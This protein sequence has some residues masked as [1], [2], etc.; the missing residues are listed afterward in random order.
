MTAERI[1][2]STIRL[3]S[4]TISRITTPSAEAFSWNVACSALDGLPGSGLNIAHEAIDRHVARG[5]GA[6]T[7]V[8]G[9]PGSVPSFR[10]HNAYSKLPGMTCRSK[11]TGRSFKPLCIGLNCAM[12][13]SPSFYLAVKLWQ[14]AKCFLVGFGFFLQ[15]QRRASRRC[16]AL[17]RSVQ[18][19]KGAGLSAG[20][21]FVISIN[22]FFYC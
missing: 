18:R 11:S 12:S 1:A 8:G 21:D 9:K 17:S 13:H 22:F 4:H 7:A 3:A 10:W 5:A 19:L 6:K 15:P 16:A 14:I 20:L 2:K